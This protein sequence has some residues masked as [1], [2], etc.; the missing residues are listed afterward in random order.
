[1]PLHDLCRIQT[2]AANVLQQLGKSVVS[3]PLGMPDMHGLEDIEV[4]GS[5]ASSD[6]A[7]QEQ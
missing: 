7:Q 6:L 3:R 4:I 2:S 1:M 5:D